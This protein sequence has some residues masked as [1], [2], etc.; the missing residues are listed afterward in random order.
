[1][2]QQQKPPSPQITNITKP[3]FLFPNP[4]LPR[5]IYMYIYI[6]RYGWKSKHRGG[7]PQNG[8]FIWWK[9]L[10]KWMIWREKTH[11]FWKHPYDIDLWKL[12]AYIYIHIIVIKTQLDLTPPSY[13]RYIYTHHS[14]PSIGQSIHPSLYARRPIGSLQGR[15]ITELGSWTKHGWPLPVM[16]WGPGWW[17]QGWMDMDIYIYILNN[18]IYKNIIYN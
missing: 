2:F 1:M 15:D 17:G 4:P 6:N 16:L 10:L 9:S 7:S 18:N 11:D 3:E 5:F 8:W 14:S 12:W 13:L